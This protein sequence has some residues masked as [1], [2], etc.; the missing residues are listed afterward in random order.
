MM[1]LNRPP[2]ASLLP[3]SEA[4]LRAVADAVARDIAAPGEALDDLTDRVLPA[5][6]W[7]VDRLAAAPE[8]SEAALRELREAGARMAREG[9]PLQRMLDRYL[10]AG[11]VLWGEASRPGAGADADALAALGRALLLGL[12][13][14]AAAIGEGYSEAERALVART[15]A[16]RREYLDELLELPA[17]DV[18]AAARIRRRGAQFG[19]DPTRESRILVADLG[20]ELEESGPEL[21]RIARA[22]ERPV[23]P[24]RA[25]APAG[26]QAPIATTRR[27]LLVVLAAESVAGRLEIDEQFEGLASGTWRAVATPAVHGPAAIGAA[28]RDAVESL[29]AARRAGR[30]GRMGTDEV[31]LE[32][33]LLADE[34]L[35]RRALD[36]ELGALRAHGRSGVAL[37]ATLRTWL[38]NGQNVRATARV[39]DL[40]P[41]TVAY[42]L[43]RIEGI[44]G[45]SIRG[46]VVERLAAALILSD[47]IAEEAEARP[48]TPAAAP[49]R[50]APRGRSRSRRSGAPAR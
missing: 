50:R 31:L 45:R 20:H 12:D 17:G 14:V 24:D 35:A 40:A 3:S 34:D 28:Y 5:V 19:F 1:Q 41:R 23:R 47:L 15:A 44:L 26:D 27:G 38:G 21:E 48:A 9:E 43:A 46:A 2:Y 11:W 39:L 18:A 10:S 32:R 49:R 13:R 42:R 29:A 4:S 30:T 37:L 6:T 8:L 36:A 16:A 22:L 7:I 33:A 25:G